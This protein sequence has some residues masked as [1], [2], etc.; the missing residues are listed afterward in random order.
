[1]DDKDLG[2]ILGNIVVTL[3]QLQ[4]Y[5]VDFYIG[6]DSRTGD[7]S[8]FIV[9]DG[10]ESYLDFYVLHTCPP[11]LKGLSRLETSLNV[12]LSIYKNKGNE[13]SQIFRNINLI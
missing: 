10:V 4:Q 5:G 7:I 6:I 8:L 13:P 12:I 11:D 9:I 2:A 1:M 3:K